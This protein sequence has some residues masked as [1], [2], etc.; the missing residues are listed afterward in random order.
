LCS[1][2]LV[3]NLALQGRE[4]EARHLYAQL[5]DYASP[6]GLLSEMVEPASGELL[7]NYPQAFSHVGLIRAALALDHVARSPVNATSR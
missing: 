7:G 5:L 4:E 6:T 3:E 2:W 1:C